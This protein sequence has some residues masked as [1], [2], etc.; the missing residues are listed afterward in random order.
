MANQNA[1]VN[2]PVKRL[3]RD[4]STVALQQ[5][6]TAAVAMR[7]QEQAILA[8]EKEGPGVEGFGNLE[9]ARIRANT[10]VELLLKTIG[11]GFYGFNIALTAGVPGRIIQRA[12]SPRGYL[13][14]NPAEISG[15]TA[16]VTFYA[17]A[18]RA[19]GFVTPSTSFNVSGVDTARVF[20]DITA[21]ANTP[22]L[23][24]D[25]E[26]QDPLT[27]NWAVS[28]ADIFGGTIIV[29]T[30]Y[31]SLGT[32]GIDKTMRLVAEV[33]NAAL[34]SITFSVSGLFKGGVVTSVGSTIYLGSNDVNTTF[35]YPILPGQE[36]TF[37]LMDNV[38]L[39]AISPLNPMTVKVFQL[40]G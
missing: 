31:A 15:F 8:Y 25:A 24:I 38:E 1:P 26:T 6:K 34:D 7:N 32:L 21:T 19:N 13:I 29:G 14:L 37:Y 9:L 28:Q 20:L 18:L 35:G 22:T 17:S 36:K 16:E 23:I 40:Q 39:Y 12:K 4:L 5:A 33:G 10:D 11:L 30:Y 3:P 27:G 2:Y